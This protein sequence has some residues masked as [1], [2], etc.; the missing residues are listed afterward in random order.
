M[1]RVMALDVLKRAGYHASFNDGPATLVGPTNQTARSVSSAVGS[2]TIASSADAAA[3]AGMSFTIGGYGSI[4][5]SNSSSGNIGISRL[6]P[7]LSRSTARF[8]LR[9]TPPPLQPPTAAGGA[10]QHQKQLYDTKHPAPAKQPS[11]P[12]ASLAQAESIEHIIKSFHPP[13]DSAAAQ[14]QASKVKTAQ[15]QAAP[16]AGSGGVDYG[17]LLADIASEAK[18]TGVLAATRIGWATSAANEAAAAAA[19]VAAAAASVASPSLPSSSGGSKAVGSGSSAT[20]EKKGKAASASPSS[21]AA[22][23][24]QTGPKVAGKAQSSDSPFVSPGRKA[25]ASPSQPSSSMIH[26]PAAKR[27]RSAGDA[28][29]SASVESRALDGTDRYRESARAADFDAD[30][31]HSDEVENNKEEEDLAELLVRVSTSAAVSAELSASSPIKGGG[32]KRQ[33]LGQS[34]CRN[35]DNDD[36]DSGDDGAAFAECLC[37]SLREAGYDISVWESGVSMTPVR[38]A[39]AKRTFAA[40]DARAAVNQY[41]PKSSVGATGSGSA[42]SSRRELQWM[43]PLSHFGYRPCLDSGADTAGA[44]APAP[45]P[46]E[47]YNRWRLVD[48]T[49]RR[50]NSYASASA[51]DG[52]PASI[53]PPVSASGASTEAPS[54]TSNAAGSNEDTICAVTDGGG[55]APAVAEF[56]SAPTPASPAAALG[57]RTSSCPQAGGDDG[58]RAS[59]TSPASS[60][61]TVALMGG[62]GYGRFSP[63]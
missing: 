59:F 26:E 36:G 54:R 53:E 44:S 35:N 40:L 18:L 6:A 39:E 42:G 62:R 10:S 14:P 49:S 8:G 11:G 28:Y 4:S 5:S 19:A 58:M 2:S 17:R 1:S 57:G 12:V 46:A 29:E 15:A 21:S 7:S 56:T 37:S 32:F 45:S 34:P 47:R 38:A 60:V 22:T 9:P 16:S 52:S 31:S 43:P 13:R 61:A 20:P 3:G 41:A 30:A 25:K 24:E 33:R 55:K 48:V 50:C 23:I 63:A 27:R 51:R